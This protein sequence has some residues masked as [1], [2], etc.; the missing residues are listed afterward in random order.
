[1]EQLIH[2]LVVEVV[3]VMMQQVNLV[4]PEV[5]EVIQLKDVVMQED[6]LLLKDLMV[7]VVPVDQE[8][9]LVVEVVVALLK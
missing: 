5:V 4:V 7:D 3:E 1:V 9:V 6:I 2:P 8:I